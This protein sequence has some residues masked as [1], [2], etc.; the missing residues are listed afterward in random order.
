[1]DAHYTIETEPAR[2]LVRI[3]LSG[4]FSS[5]DVG[6]FNAERIAAYAAFGPAIKRHVTLC[7]VRALKIQPQEVVAAFAEL[8]GD[9]RYISRRLA[10]VTGASLAKTQTK[11]A[12]ERDS[13]AY[14]SNTAEAEAWLLS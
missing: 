4:F 7:D 14:F 3:T 8:A 5:G 1:M 9:P 13:V 2:D 6:R 11:R 12:T 10:V